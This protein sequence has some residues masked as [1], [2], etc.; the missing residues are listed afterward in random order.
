MYLYI[1]VY[2][3]TLVCVY[4]DRDIYNLFI[5]TATAKKGEKA[6]LQIKDE[7]DTGAKETERRWAM[8]SGGGERGRWKNSS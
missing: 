2:M 1:Y 5:C 8:G 3:H 7:G 6:K 4:V